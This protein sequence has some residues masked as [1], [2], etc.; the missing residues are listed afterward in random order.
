MSL[1][2]E[3]RIEIRVQTAR[4]RGALKVALLERDRVCL[5]CNESL[6]G[7]IPHM[8]EGII[9][10]AE[11]QGWPLAQ[12]VLIYTEYNCVLLCPDCNLGLSGR[13]PP[14]RERVI[15]VQHH[16]Y[17]LALALWLTSLPFKVLPPAVEAYL[18]QFGLA[19]FGA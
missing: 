18:E 4:A 16:R 17:G 12:R 1:S 9:S 15:E 7:V 14:T 5:G 11:V 13:H 19:R 10:R 3:E 8:H 2:R 6:I